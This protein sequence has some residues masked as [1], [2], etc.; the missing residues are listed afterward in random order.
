MCD[1]HALASQ[2]AELE[3]EMEKFFDDALISDIKETPLT[4]V[5]GVLED[6]NQAK[7]QRERVQRRAKEMLDED[8][9]KEKQAREVKD[10]EEAISVTKVS[11]PAVAAVTKKKDGKKPAA[12]AA[13]PSSDDAAAA[14]AKASATAAAAELPFKLESLGVMRSREANPYVLNLTE[15]LPEQE[16]TR[17]ARDLKAENELLRKCLADA[18]KGKGGNAFEGFLRRNAHHSV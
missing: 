15:F 1:V 2:A 9:E 14:D 7:E 16:A 3:A 5:D 11:E 8:L 4:T 12:A 18:Q 6:R 13:A 17:Q 10:L